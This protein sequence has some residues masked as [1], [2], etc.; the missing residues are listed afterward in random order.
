[1]RRAWWRTSLPRVLAGFL[2]GATAF[3]ACTPSGPR[4]AAQVVADPALQ[5]IL[6]HVPADTPYAFVSMGSKGAREFIT[7]IYA[8]LQPL[9]PQLEGKLAAIDSLGL[10]DDKAALARAVV[11]ELKGRL[12]VDGLAELGLDVDGRFAFYGLGLLPAMRMQLRDPAAL[13]A[14]VERVQAKSGTRFPT[15][16]LG[17]VEYWHI[18]GDKVEGAVAII[19]DQLVAGVAPVAQKDRVFALLLGAELPARHLGNSEGFQQLL[20]EYGLARVSAGFVDA[21]LIAE[22]FLGEGDPLNRDILA[23]LA[24][25]V[26]ARGPALGD[27]CKQEIRSLVALA[28]RLVF[29]TEQIDGDGF[30][31][32]FVL[33]LRR[34]LAQELMA[35]RTTVP[36]L[37][38]EALKDA[39]FAMGAGVDVERVLNFAQS[40]AIALQTAPYSCPALAAINEAAADAIGEF[41]AIEPEVWKTRGF[42]LV[43]DELKLTG[44]VPTMVRGF[45]S[46]AYTDTK[47]LVSKLSGLTRLPITDDGT[48]TALPDN[49]IPFLTDVHYGVKAG[50][51]GAIAVGAGSEARARALVAF[52][53]QADPPLLVIV[54]DMTR[55]A[56]L[57]GSF[58]ENAGTKPE[59]MMLIDLYKAFGSITY[60]MRASERGVV[61]N[62]RMSLR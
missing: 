43:L 39:A 7:K 56:E 61:I 53:E 16:K 11:D 46:L 18:A 58:V 24:P 12:S 34:D 42:A 6:Q 20:A 25:E 45:V 2:V 35:M 44:M 50:V 51:G 62:T 32:K 13:R 21:R 14:A 57:M 22:A 19:G 55:L 8:P 40:K 36:G 9:V 15:G 29:G 3:A 1:M 49:A 17:D 41:K 23:A 26:A 37:D 38:P 60:D 28:P 5:Q 27:T 10:P 48:V 31:G 54:Y 33:E 4:D 47:T 59:M 52:T 30:S